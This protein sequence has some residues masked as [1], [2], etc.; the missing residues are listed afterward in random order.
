MDCYSQR[1]KNLMS[2]QIRS[3]KLDGKVKKDLILTRS[4]VLRKY[5][6]LIRLQNNIENL[7]LLLALDI[8]N[9][10]FTTQNRPFSELWKW[11]LLP[12]FHVESYFL[13]NVQQKSSLNYHKNTR[14]GQKHRLCSYYLDV[15]LISFSVQ[16]ILPYFIQLTTS[17]NY[18][19]F[20][21]I[22]R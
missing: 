20:S 5:H 4:Y 16:N 21:F 1:Q 2:I 8:A 14:I 22:M 6:T 10:N 19:T 3:I 11:Y 12:F 18:I 9:R 13:E 15:D 7:N 17:R